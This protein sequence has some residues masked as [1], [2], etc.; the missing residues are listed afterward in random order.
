MS[1]AV[2]ADA[3]AYIDGIAPGH[4]PLFDRLH[5]LILSMRPAVMVVLA[6]R[7]PTY[8][9][10]HRRLYV[11]AWKHG[12]SLDGLPQGHDGGFTA[13]HPGLLAGKGSI[14]LRPEAA[15]G[16]FDSELRDLIRAALKPG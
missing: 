13:R 10:G 2:S 7:M 4:R 16:I 1:S 15:A 5:R 6:Y 9:A 8:Q 3:Q 11:G 12:I 14:R